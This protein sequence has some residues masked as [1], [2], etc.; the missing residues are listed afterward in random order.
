MR[1][2]PGPHGILVLRG[3]SPRGRLDSQE[4]SGIVANHGKE[5]ATAE[6][7]EDQNASQAREGSAEESSTDDAADSIPRS[8]TL[9]QDARR[10]RSQRRILREEPIQT[11]Y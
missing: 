7:A 10:G 4:D 9:E 2:A 3:N 1:A 5:K 8:S 11:G 6:E